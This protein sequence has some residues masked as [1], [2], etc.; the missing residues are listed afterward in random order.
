VFVRVNEY[1]RI[2]VLEDPGT[3]QYVFWLGKPA[4]IRDE[5]IEAIQI[6]LREFPDAEAM[7]MPR[8][9]IKKGDEMKIVGGAFDGQKGIVKGHKNE[10]VSLFLPSI[11]M[12]VK[13]SAAYLAKL[14]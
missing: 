7:A 5:E 8:E 14:V 3:I 2:Q 1:E 9:Q 10:D 4:I 12:V 11:G 13:V 6:F